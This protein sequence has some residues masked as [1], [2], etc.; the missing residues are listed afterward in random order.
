MALGDVGLVKK[1]K[2]RYWCGTFFR[3][4]TDSEPFTAYLTKQAK[5]QPEK[6]GPYA[7]LKR[8]L[9]FSTWPVALTADFFPV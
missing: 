7:F 4:K 5:K 2:L 3:K 1:A 9:N 6:N 8:L